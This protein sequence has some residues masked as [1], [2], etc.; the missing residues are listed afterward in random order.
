MWIRF[1][2]TYCRTVPEL[3]RMCLPLRLHSRPDST[4][5]KYECVCCPVASE[6]TDRLC[7]WWPNTE[8]CAK[9]ILCQLVRFR[10]CCRCIWRLVCRSCA[11]TAMLTQ[12]G[13]INHVPELIYQ[14]SREPSDLDIEHWSHCKRE[15]AKL[16]N[17]LPAFIFILL[18]NPTAK[19]WSFRRD[20][21]KRNP[22][23]LH[24]ADTLVHCSTVV[25]NTGRCSSQIEIYYRKQTHQRSSLSVPFCWF[26]AVTLLSTR[27]NNEN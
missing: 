15:I 5:A 11:R 2:S 10:V 12:P 22:V 4:M 3:H 27:W 19:I 8:S 14:S 24:L 25:N 13:P 9:A 16:R 20:C 23:V 26:T 1:V 7:N 18:K 21:D 17:W 6:C